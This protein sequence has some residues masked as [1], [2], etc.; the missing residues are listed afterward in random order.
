MNKKQ[1]I[2]LCILDGWGLDNQTQHNAIYH[3]DTPNFDRAHHQFPCTELNASG[4]DVGLPATQFGNSEVGHQTIGAGRI[5][6]QDIDRVTEALSSQ[7][8]TIN[9][10]LGEHSTQTIHLIG[11]ASSGG[12]HSHIN[13]FILMIQNI[14]TLKPSARIALHLITD[15]RDRPPQSVLN[16]LQP[17][18]TIINRDNNLFIASIMGRYFAMDRDQNWSRTQ[19]AYDSLVTPSENINTL[20]EYIE[21]YYQHETS[22][23]NTPS[24]EF[25]PPKQLS[26][27][28]IKEGDLVAILNFRADRAI[29]LTKAL[30]EKMDALKQSLILNSRNVLTATQYPNTSNHLHILCPPIQ[31]KNTLG[32]VLSQNNITQF[33]L[34]ET[35]KYAHVTY[36]FNAGTTNPEPKEHH[37]LIP[38]PHVKTYDLQPDMSAQNVTESVIN[39]NLNDSSFT[40]VNYAN[41]DMVGHTGNFQATIKAIQA[42]D[43]ELGKLITWAENNN[44]L[45]M[46]TADHGNA[47]CMFDEHNQQPHTR[48]TLA[49]VPFIVCTHDKIKLKEHGSLADIAPTIL[50]SFGIPKPHDMTGQSI[51]D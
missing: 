5:I 17:L 30:T 15:G 35:E 4:E 42:V 38:S 10:W 41:P 20:E 3:A 18:Y 6:S 33:R 23:N 11:L 27:N 48:H 32:Q 26:H 46:I 47:D 14:R 44:V 1:N 2:C 25:I 13:H 51:Y 22:G 19:V 43:Q 37:I 31:I 34:A 12:V 40:V 24:D 21:Q 39:C 7:S 45:L 28:N 9:Q 29:Q 50:A 8:K 36:F 16:D 49:K